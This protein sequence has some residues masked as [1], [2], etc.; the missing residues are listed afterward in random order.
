MN[1]SNFFAALAEKMGIRLQSGGGQTQGLLVSDF[2]PYFADNQQLLEQNFVVG[3]N[4]GASSANLS[5]TLTSGRGPAKGLSLAISGTGTSQAERED[6]SDTI[7]TIKIN[8]T[9]VLTNV[10]AVEYS[11]FFDSRRP[12][13]LAGYPVQS[14]IEISARKLS[15]TWAGNLTLNTLL[16]YVPIQ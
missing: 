3:L 5:E 1:L 16:Y 11:R 7:I 6:L 4:S 12:I 10:P 9:E 14:T 8:G 2:L 15:G 13:F